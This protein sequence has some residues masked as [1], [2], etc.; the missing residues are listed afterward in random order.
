[1]TYTLLVF[2]I[3]FTLVS[4][5]FFL[6]VVVGNGDVIMG[7][8]NGDGIVGIGNGDGMGLVFPCSS[9]SFVVSS[10]VLKPCKI[11]SVSLRVGVMR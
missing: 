3:L 4:F 11:A 2:L 7:V 8:G 9:W 6:A 10:S 1:M 5:V